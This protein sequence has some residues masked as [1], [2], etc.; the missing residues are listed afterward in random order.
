[1]TDQVV[2]ALRSMRLPCTVETAY[3]RF[4]WIRKYVYH[5]QQDSRMHLPV[6]I[7]ARSTPGQDTRMPGDELPNTMPPPPIPHMGRFKPAAQCT[8][9]SGSGNFPPGSNQLALTERR[10][11]A[12][13]SASMR[14]PP[15]PTPRR[16][17]SRISQASQSS[18]PFLQSNRFQPGSTQSTGASSTI[19]QMSTRFTEGDSTASKF[20]GGQRMAFVPGKTTGHG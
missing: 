15:P 16:P 5:E 3:L 18:A 9:P 11:P 8:H 7:Y 19:P 14:P 2:V 20:S 10:I 12:E 4:F 13:P 17:F 1:M 6:P